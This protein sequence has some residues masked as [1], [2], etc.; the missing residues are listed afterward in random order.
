MQTTT[1]ATAMTEAKTSVRWKIFLMMLFL[2]A[3][4]YIDR[5]SLSVAMPLIA[6]EFD[7]S[8]TMQGLILSSFFWTYA[9]MQVP[10]GMLADKYKPRIVI[11]CATVF[12]GIAQAVAAFTTNATSLLLTRL[13]LGAAEAPIYPAGGKL[14]AIWMTQN[15]RGRG[16]TLLDGGAPLGAALG[17]IIITWLIAS[18]GSWRLAF[19]VAGVGTVLAGV[20]AW[21][22]VRNSPREHRGVNELEA[23]YIEEALASEHRAEPANLSGRSLDFFKYRS[24]WC[25]AIGWMCFNTVFY[26]LLTWMPNYL[27]KVHGFDIKQMGGASFIIF[28]SGFVGELIGGWIADK[29]KEAGGRPNVVMRTLFGIAAV[30]ATASIFSVAYVTDPVVVVVLLSSTLFFLRWCGLFWCVP[31]MLGTR[32]K[33][34]FLGGVMNLGGNIGGIS[35]PIIVGMIVQFTGS[36]FLALMF[37]AA[38]GV[39][40]LLAS[41]AIDYETKIPV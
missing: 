2:I 1:R 4:N 39:G 3:I 6:K 23:R 28:F 35:V 27:N 26:G 12:W 9:L 41:T 21:Y 7:L 30:V 29:W 36:Y 10:G 19:I 14:N 33:V 17:A 38:A 34:G 20:L 5:A 40:L 16:A 37:F 18:L 8:P 11:A 13:G 32:N 22:Y 24:V 15:E 31:S 25:M